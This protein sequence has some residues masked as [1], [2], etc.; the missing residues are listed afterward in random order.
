M[1][2]R[3]QT[4]VPPAARVIIIAKDDRARLDALIYRAIASPEQSTTYLAPLANE[5]RRAR[6]VPRAEVPRDVV[7][8]NATVRL[9]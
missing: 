3:V 6:V 7:T 2:K 4:T 9:G 5:L 1:P 8:M